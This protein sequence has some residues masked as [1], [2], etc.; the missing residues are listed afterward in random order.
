M[1]KFKQILIV[2]ISL[3]IFLTAPKLT[4]NA[5]GNNAGGDG[6]SGGTAEGSGGATE[7]KCGFRMYVVN[8]KGLLV[9]KVVDLV[10]AEPTADKSAMTTRIGGGTASDIIATNV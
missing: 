7:S 3:L 1:I 2:F 10:C 9:S 5:M 6:N 4:T 8:E